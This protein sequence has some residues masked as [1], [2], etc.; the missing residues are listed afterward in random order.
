[1]I[2]LSLLLTGA[3]GEPEPLLYSGLLSGPGYCHNGGVCVP[4]VYCALHYADHVYSS[5]SSPCWLAINTPGICCYPTIPTVPKVAR[6]LSLYT[7][8]ISC[9]RGLL[10][11]AENPPNSK[12]PIEFDAYS[13]NH[14]AFV[15]LN[16]VAWTAEFEKELS[17]RNV[18]VNKVD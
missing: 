12:S 5:S 9:Q 7:F 6:H 18:Y 16:E 2:L 11:R 17:R 10:R 1:M 15:G 4:H 3:A 8:S 14:A 13:L